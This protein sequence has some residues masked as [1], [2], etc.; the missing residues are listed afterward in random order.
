MSMLDSKGRLF[1]RI[2]VIDAA[3]LA[4]VIAALPVAAVAYR[5]MRADAVDV[6]GLTPASVVAGE[7]ARLKLNGSGF[8]AY[9]QAYFAPSGSPFV[10]TQADRMSQNTQ[11]LLSS[12]VGAEL[13][14]P[15]LAP[16]TYDLYLYDQGRLLAA[17][18][19]AS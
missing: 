1:G 17:R 13:Q 18:P 2:N 6:S 12:A 4:M 14:P 16:G 7:P 15:A 10:L 3:V 8:R 19:A 9:L 11:Y 5:S